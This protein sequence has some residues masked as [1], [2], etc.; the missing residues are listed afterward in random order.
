MMAL[1]KGKSDVPLKK[2]S[3]PA[4]KMK[5]SI[6]PDAVKLADNASNQKNGQQTARRKVRKVAAVK[7]TVSKRPRPART[8]P[9]APPENSSSPLPPGG[10]R[11]LIGNTVFSNGSVGAIVLSS[12]TCGEGKFFLNGKF[13]YAAEKNKYVPPILLRMRT[14]G[15]L[16]LSQATQLKNVPLRELEST[17]LRDYEEIHPLY[18]DM[19]KQQLIFSTLSSFVTWEEDENVMWEWH[20]GERTTLLVCEELERSMALLAVEERL[21]QWTVLERNYSQVTE[22]DT[23]PLRGPAWAGFAD[24]E[25]YSSSFTHVVRKV[26]GKTTVRLLAKRSGLTPFEVAS[27]LAKAVNDDIVTFE[28]EDNVPETVDVV[29]ELE[30][31]SPPA[32]SDPGTSAGDE[33]GEGIFRSVEVEQNKPSAKDFISEE[34]EHA[35]NVLT[36]APSNSGFPD[37]MSDVE[38]EYVDYGDVVQTENLQPTLVE[39]ATVGEE[40]FTLGEEEKLFAADNLNGSAET[41]FPPPQVTGPSFL[42]SPAWHVS[43]KTLKQA[44]QDTLKMLVE[45]RTRLEKA[46]QYNAY[47]GGVIEGRLSSV[48]AGIDMIRKNNGWVE[49]HAGEDS[50]T[51]TGE[52]TVPGEFLPDR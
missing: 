35:G 45:E 34:D 6:P 20:P 10:I 12:P 16:T 8:T 48:N 19:L 43:A 50:Q 37:S 24:E 36:D 2:P 3:L 13:L 4:P 47:V 14:E 15:A 9:S 22:S 39:D 41:L 46:L 11:E 40:T 32:E 51:G 23:V 26:N 38:I 5:S 52:G 44:T 31:S 17:L 49:K 33:G 25:V 21:G 29:E 7:K 27:I 18:F 30:K 1:K 28:E 42:T